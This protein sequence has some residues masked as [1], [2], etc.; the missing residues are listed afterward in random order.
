MFGTCTSSDSGSAT[1]RRHGE[2]ACRRQRLTVIAG[3]MVMICCGAASSVQASCGDYLFTRHQFPMEMPGILDFRSL[4]IEQSRAESEPLTGGPE[5]PDRPP[6]PTPPRRCQGPL[7]RQAPYVPASSDSVPPQLRWD[8][9]RALLTA[10]AW[11]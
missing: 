1:C 3:A 10:S 8:D 5:F 2:D 4:D 11:K 7:C 9:A 6:E